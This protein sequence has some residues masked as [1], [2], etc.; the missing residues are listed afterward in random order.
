MDKY[1]EK[2]IDE[3]NVDNNKIDAKTIILYLSKCNIDELII[4]KGAIDCFIAS[5]N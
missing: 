4:I 3:L 5:K 1:F 2:L